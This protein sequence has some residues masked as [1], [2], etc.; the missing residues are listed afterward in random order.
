MRFS[1]TD[2]RRGG[3]T[4]TPQALAALPGRIRTIGSGRSEYVLHGVKSL[5]AAV[6]T[7]QLIA[8]WLPGQ[9]Q[10]LGVATA[11]FMAN[12]PTVYSSVVHA[13][14][15]VGIQVLGVFLAV[16]AAWLLGATAG[17]ILAV[18]TAVLLTGRRGTGEDRLQ[19]ASTAL[20][21]L[22]AAAAAPVG[23]VASPVV[24]TL[25]GAVVGVVVNALVLPATHLTQS[26]AAV[27][28][29]ARCTG[30]LLQDMGRGLKG[31]PSLTHVSIWLERARDLERQLS[32]AREEVQTAAESLRWNVR[33]GARRQHM[34]PVYE[35]ALEVLHTASFQVRG[36]A[37][38]LADSMGRG[39]HPGLNGGF[40]VR[41]A[42]ALDLAGQAFMTYAG[43][44]AAAGSTEVDAQRHLHTVIERMRT[45][46]AGM[47]DL[48]DRGAVGTPDAWHVYGSLVVDVERLLCDLDD[49]TPPQGASPAAVVEINGSRC[50]ASMIRA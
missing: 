15:R 31:E 18:L 1:P 19:I 9:Q 45:W 39:V 12:A 41:Y 2:R 23:H 42:E 25:T 27:R 22:T 24:S 28:R 37:R 20:I 47:T 4:A 33:A 7:W 32:E 16:V 46:H 6:L 50:I 29:L 3:A 5:I 40:A 49:T 34:I 8:L 11:L 26:D 38:T 30:T 21:T 43:I 10:F 35:G 48:I 36:I 44:G 14:R 17:G 13:A